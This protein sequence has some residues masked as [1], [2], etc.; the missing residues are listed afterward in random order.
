MSG[1]E[2]RS[3]VVYCVYRGEY[4]QVECAIEDI[5]LRDKTSCSAIDI[6]FPYGGIL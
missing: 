3:V 6:V 1:I 5:V 4:F 2:I